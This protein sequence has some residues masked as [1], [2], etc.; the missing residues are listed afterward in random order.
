MTDYSG[1]APAKRKSI[2]GGGGGESGGGV[3]GATAR[4]KSQGKVRG[5]PPVQV[6]TMVLLPMFRASRKLSPGDFEITKSAF[7]ESETDI[8]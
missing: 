8:F 5:A 7:S 2:T 1:A 4:R 6:S 3:S